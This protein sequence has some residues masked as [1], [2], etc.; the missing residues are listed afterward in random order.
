MDFVARKSTCKAAIN[1]AHSFHR[2]Q[3]VG[4]AFAD[5]HRNAAEDADERRVT[6]QPQS[7]SQMAFEEEVALHAS[8]MLSDMHDWACEKPNIGR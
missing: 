7:R 4:S 6:S 8:S 3:L 1:M 5:W 2:E